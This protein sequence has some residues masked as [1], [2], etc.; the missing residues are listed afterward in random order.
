MNIKNILTKQQIIKLGKEIQLYQNCIIKI[1]DMIE[2]KKYA[3][4]KGF[5][6]FDVNTI[7]YFTTLVQ[8]EALKFMLNEEDNNEIGNFMTANK[9]NPV[10]E[11]YIIQISGTIIGKNKY[12]G[13]I[14]YSVDIGNNKIV[15]VNDKKYN[16][17]IITKDRIKEL[18]GN[19]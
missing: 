16:I 4:A 1:D 6:D 9:V 10:N 5:I 12:E 2:C 11:D 3:E 19:S 14:F 17:T 8:S 18:M 15:I 13:Y 7:S